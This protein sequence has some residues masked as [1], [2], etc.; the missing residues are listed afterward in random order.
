MT[1]F[2]NAK[3]NIGLRIV[4]RRDDGFHNIETIFYPVL[5]RDALEFV[6][7]DDGSDSDSLTVT[8]FVTGCRMSE[9][10]VVKAVNLLRRSFNI[11]ALQI[12]LHKAIPPGAGLGGGSSDAAFTIR[13]LN[14]YYR[15]GLCNNTLMELALELGSDCPFFIDNVPAFATGR[16]EVLSSLQ[17]LMKGYHI[18]LIN[19]GI[20]INTG[21]AY[22]R[23][24]PTRPGNSLVD[25]YLQPVEEWKDNIFN[26]FEPSVFGIYPEIGRIKE[27]LYDNGALY[28]SM[29]GSGSSV[30]GIFRDKPVTIKQE[31]NYFTW[32][33]V[34]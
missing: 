28:A 12:H 30:F 31:K 19:P 20:E 7:S 17:P 13:Y 8:G 15:L 26:D 18:M 1:F 33:S 29:S 14:R 16:G 4:A 10:L 11:P 25:L 23:I 5:L 24:T 3:I 34:M 9:N 21:E 2:P 22:R 32:S 6:S 27:H